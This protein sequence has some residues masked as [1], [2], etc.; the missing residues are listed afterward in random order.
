MVVIV[1]ARYINVLLCVTYA[2]YL[3]GESHLSPRSTYL[4]MKE[5]KRRDEKTRRRKR[6]SRIVKDEAR[7]KEEVI[8]D[9]KGIKQKELCAGG[10][11]SGTL[12][13][14]VWGGRS[15]W[16]TETSGWPVRLT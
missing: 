5:G 15:T 16:R 4:K 7:Q 8:T 6:P 9:E 12:G 10:G 2:V 11:H 14:V 13:Q 1:S 3:L